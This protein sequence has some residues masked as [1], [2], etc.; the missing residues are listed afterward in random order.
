MLLDCVFSK[1][2]FDLCLL[3][4]GRRLCYEAWSIFAC[5]TNLHVINELANQH[6]VATYQS[7]F[8]LVIS[9]AIKRSSVALQAYEFRKTVPLDA[10]HLISSSPIGL[11]KDRVSRKPRLKVGTKHAR[12]L[13]WCHRFPKSY[14][15]A[16]LVGLMGFP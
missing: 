13:N 4:L 2:V 3:C 12:K 5:L 9:L 10:M 7:Q 14:S 11:G 1:R 8:A 15:G 16:A 6:S